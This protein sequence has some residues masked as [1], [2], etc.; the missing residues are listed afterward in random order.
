MV[1]PR[2]SWADLARTTLTFGY[3]AADL[4]KSKQMT[5]R[6]REKSALFTAYKNVNDN[7]NFA[8]KFQ[9]VFCVHFLSQVL[10][11]TDYV[12]GFSEYFWTVLCNQRWLLSRASVTEDCPTE[13][14]FSCWPEKRKLALLHNR[15]IEVREQILIEHRVH[16]SV[17]MCHMLL[18][19]M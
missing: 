14:W 4:V 2:S 5:D 9:L 19:P 6:I 13:E 16:G 17:L 10:W 15:M 11:W 18:F 3:S 8:C 1:I 12:T 7:G